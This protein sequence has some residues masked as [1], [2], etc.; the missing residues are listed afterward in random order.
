MAEI[1]TSR[2]IAPK[3]FDFIGNSTGLDSNQY[4]V[5][6]SENRSGIPLEDKAF[7]VDY[8]K[9][10]LIRDVARP[11]LF[12]VNIV[13]PDIIY[14]K[15][16]WANGSRMI[17]ALAK[18]AVFPQ[19]SVREYVL[20]RA[21]QKLHIPTNEM[22]YGEV[23]ITFINDADFTLRSI[24]N[25]WQRIAIHNWQAN[26]GSVPLLAL[27]SH[28]SIHQYDSALNEVYSV[29]L[30]NA[31]PQTIS[32]IELSQDSE[33]SIETFSVDFKFTQHSVFKKY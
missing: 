32:S 16:E 23:S 21:G 8:L 22:D 12:K 3:Q 11:N 5:N 1:P 29:K 14:K 17:S 13:P 6:I 2:N 24:F 10:Q 27:S 20:E 7:H 15:N 31:W 9:S 19:I 4:P 33:N 28:V 26:V 18:S 25:N 30:T